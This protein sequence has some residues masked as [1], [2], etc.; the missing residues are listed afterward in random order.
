M[1]ERPNGLCDP[2]PTNSATDTL[3]LLSEGVAGSGCKLLPKSP[4]AK[5][6]ASPPMPARLNSTLCGDWSLETGLSSVET[7]EETRV[8][9]LLARLPE[10]RKRCLVEREAS[11]YT[12]IKQNYL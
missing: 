8:T 7:G 11:I 5:S 2:G 4:R 10:P 3:A 6:Y 9:S 12:F 1:G